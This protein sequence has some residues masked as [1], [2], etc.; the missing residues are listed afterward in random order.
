M[1]IRSV[2]W[3]RWRHSETRPKLGAIVAAALHVN[4]QGFAAFKQAVLA[5]PLTEL[6]RLPYIGPVTV[7]HLAKNLGLDVAKP[8]RHLTRVSLA[9]GFHDAEQFCTAIAKVIGERR[10]VVDLIVWR[11]LAD[12]PHAFGTTVRNV[13]GKANRPYARAPDVQLESWGIPV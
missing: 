4:R 3:P 13:R 10:K 12:N 9:L 1:R 2:A 11:Y 8:D 7:W 5:A 6:Q